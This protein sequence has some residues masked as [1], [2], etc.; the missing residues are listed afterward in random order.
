MVALLK[1]E[2][3]RSNPIWEIQ[4]EMRNQKNLSEYRAIKNMI[5]PMLRIYNLSL[6]SNYFCFKFVLVHEGKKI[7]I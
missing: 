1:Q 7:G 4:F 3:N 2:K 6:I 5:F